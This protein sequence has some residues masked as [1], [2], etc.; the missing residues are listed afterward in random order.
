VAKWV[1]L[2]PTVKHSKNKVICIW[3][4]FLFIYPQKCINCG[5]EPMGH[6]NFSYSLQLSLPIYIQ[7]AAEW[8]P[9][10][11]KVTVREWWE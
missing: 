1:V 4:L 6:K 5:K 2:G 7:G 9:T 8:T 3:M 10:F 11:L